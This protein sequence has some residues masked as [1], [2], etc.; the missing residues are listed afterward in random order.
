LEMSLCN[1]FAICMAA[2]DRRI[3]AARGGD[4]ACAPVRVQIRC[5]PMN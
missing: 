1:R 5:V 4:C 3:V 2:P